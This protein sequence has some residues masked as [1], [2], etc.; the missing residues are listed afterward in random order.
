MVMPHR[1][2]SSGM[3]SIRRELQRRRPKH[4]APKSSVAMKPSAPPPPRESARCTGREPRPLP[5]RLE[6]SSSTASK[7]P[8]GSAATHAP[9]PRRRSSPRPTVFSP[10]TPLPASSAPSS[11]GSA[12][13]STL[14]ADEHLRPGT[15][16][17]V[18]TRTTTL[19]TG[20][21][22]VLWLRAMIVSPIHGGYEVVY[23]GNWPPGDPYGTVQVPR[24]HI[25]MIK[26]SPPPT[27]PPPSLPPFSASATTA[28][29]AAA[30]KKE[31]RP[32]PRPT[33]AGKSLRL[34]RRGLLP[35]MERQARADLH[36]Y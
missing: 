12:C 33:T 35:E 29:V 26:P 19:K 34:I 17:G 6:V 30:R 8:P 23:D 13:L 32:Q 1:S 7:S 21:A 36:G 25:R 18:R 16:V 27:T 4:L 28:T 11:G 24:R 9:R 10:S 31:M 5:P 20:E 14:G 22:L 2:S 3:Q 15:E